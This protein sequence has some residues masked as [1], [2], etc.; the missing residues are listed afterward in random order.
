MVHNV[1]P[2]DP[3]RVTKIDGICAVANGMKLMLELARKE[4]DLNWRTLQAQEE[5]R[6]REA[7]QNETTEMTQ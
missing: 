6:A 2:D 3:D 7:A 4:L 5:Q 1:Q